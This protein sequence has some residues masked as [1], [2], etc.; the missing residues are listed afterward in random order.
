MTSAVFF[1]ELKEDI[2]QRFW[3]SVLILAVG[4]LIMPLT[5]YYSMNSTAELV[6]EGI[7]SAKSG[8]ADFLRIYREMAGTKAALV[9]AASAV[10]GILAAV[11][12]FSW[13]G[14]QEAV[15]FWHSVAIDRKT[16]FLER[17]AA[18][19][20][21]CVIPY[22]IDWA[23]ATFLVPV[24]FSAFT[25]EI[26][27]D[28]LKAVLFFILS[29]MAFYF[30]ITL[31]LVMSGKTGTGLLL[32]ALLLLEGPA[33]VGIFSMIMSTFFGSIVMP[34]G[35]L[36]YCFS[37]VTILFGEMTGYFGEMP[38][39][40][41]SQAFLLMA[42]YA[43]AGLILGLMAYRFRPSESAGCGIVFSWTSHV[44]RVAV[45]IT[46]ALVLDLVMGGD[47]GAAG[48]VII[49]A[50]GAF[51][52]SLLYE[53]IF[54]SGLRHYRSVWKEVTVSF[55]AAAALVLLCVYDPA[56]LNSW[57]PA[58]SEVREAAVKIGVLDNYGYRSDSIQDQEE[59]Q[60]LEGRFTDRTDVIAELSDKADTGNRYPDDDDYSVL[61]GWK[62]LNG[63]TVYRRYAV[64]VSALDEFW[65]TC[66]GDEKLEN[67]YNPV[68]QFD[69]QEG[70]E[71]CVISS[72]YSG[73]EK[74]MH[75]TDE[76]CAGLRQAMIRDSEKI[77]PSEVTDLEASFVIMVGNRYTDDID[78]DTSGAYYYIYP[79][80]EETLTW[81][82][83]HGYTLAA[84][85]GMNGEDT[86]A[87]SADVEG[88]SNGDE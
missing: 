77:L 73:D 25:S 16:L 24:G 2:R 9:A 47:A 48:Q 14:R 20:F 56:G 84:E 54:Y 59:V 31:G 39:V 61:F 85:E 17:A 83:D 21:L 28:G 86:G 52:A 80:Y 69:Q 87:E 1:K 40:P 66:A 27:R 41:A 32:G 82:A 13:L 37:P 7:Y 35:I 8:A 19:F 23:A 78:Q 74:T 88:G 29:W 72:A 58:E 11:T 4:F 3:I 15:D 43:A 65:Q 75:L 26:L 81:L 38:G 33:M 10:A 60:A 44:I 50:A 79:A 67:Q 49:I 51:L 68:A 53:L 57:L 46:G 71:S 55:A 12:G 18:G 5:M 64:P 34:E 22:L 63:R 42:G 62:L 36:S 30:F 76:D 45:V 70:K 6:R